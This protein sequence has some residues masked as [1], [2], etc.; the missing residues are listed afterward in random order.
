[1]MNRKSN[2]GSFNHRH[3]RV[4]ELVKQNLGQIFLR[5]KA[6]E[7]P[8]LRNTRQSPNSEALNPTARHK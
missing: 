7:G 8:F 2:T 1:M 5:N 6:A 3:L 4:G